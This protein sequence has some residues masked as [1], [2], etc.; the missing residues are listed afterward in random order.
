MAL[1]GERS[2]GHHYLED[3]KQRG[4]RWFVV[5]GKKK[6]IVPKSIPLH[7]CIW[8]ED[9]HQAHRELGSYFRAKFKGT[10]IA[11]GGSSGKTSTKEFIKTILSEHYRVGATEKSQNGLRGVPKTLEQLCLPVDV[12]VVE[13]G[14]DAPG[15]MQWLASLVQPDVAVLT[16]I[17]EEHL[18]KLKNL[19]TVFDEECI[20]FEVT[21]ARSGKCFAPQADPWLSK[22]NPKGSVKLTPPQ[23][24]AAYASPWTHG[25]AAQNTALA[26][27]VAENMGLTSKEIQAGLNKLQLPH[28]RGNQVRLENGSIAILDHYNSNPS[29]LR[30]SL[31]LAEE[32]RKSNNLSLVLI[33]GDMLDLGEHSNVEH[34]KILPK[35]LASSAERIF[36]VGEA[37]QQSVALSPGARGARES[38]RL[39]THANAE[40]LCQW[41][42][43]LG[44]EKH[45][46]WFKGSRG[47]ALEK[48]FAW[49]H[50]PG[51]L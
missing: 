48:T 50:V 28:G 41:Q 4:A 21:W 6:D 29:S 35:I 15:E 49:F 46:L 31:E 12:L 3:A 22:K 27:A 40:A 30:G 16:S 24:S 34:Q 37:W 45:L 1:E 8:F 33:L 51:T 18:S 23:V 2:D 39:T 32:M 20:L 10:V 9:T 17:G 44:S 14:I 36:L 11:V 26:V 13:V 43:K 38:G 19:E 5:D 25:F 47:I 42:P 7:S